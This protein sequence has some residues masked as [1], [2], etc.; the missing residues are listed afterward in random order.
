MLIT[1]R[2]NPKIKQ[3]RKLA[4]SKKA[5]A[6][7][8]LFTV[9]GMRNVLDILGLADELGT[10]KVVSVFY[11]KQ[12]LEKYRGQLPVERIENFDERSCYEITEQIADKMSVVGQT[13]GAFA[14]VE[15]LDRALSSEELIHNGKYLI[16]NNIQDP[17]NLGTMLRTSA[18]VGLNGVILSNNTTDLYNPKVVRSA[19]GSMPRVGIYIENNFEK[20]LSLMNKAG[21]RTYAAVVSGGKDIRKND[22]S[23]GCA[24][25]VGNEGK[26]LSNDHAEMCSEKLTISMKGSMDS[27]NAAIAGTIFLWEM[28]CSE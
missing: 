14:E 21:I 26:G 2:D 19:M 9:E 7:F 23:G 24:V 11:T 13:Q 17:G 18:A 25:V 4:S 1:G 15:M 8:R 28:S 27:L 10:F 20:V 16:L 3:Y 22:F 12:A 5:R 6:E